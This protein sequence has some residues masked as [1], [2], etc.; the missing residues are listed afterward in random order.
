MPKFINDNYAQMKMLPISY[1]KQI[2]PGT[3]ES[4]LVYLIDTKLDFKIFHAR[5]HHDDNG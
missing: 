2:L 4:S 3:F 1:D 5:Y